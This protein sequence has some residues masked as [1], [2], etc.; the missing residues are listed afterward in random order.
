MFFR[1]IPLFL[2]RVM[3][4]DHRHIMDGFVERSML[5][6]PYCAILLCH[7]IYVPVG[8]ALGTLASCP[9]LLARHLGQH[10]EKLTDERRPE[11][12]YLL[13][14]LGGRRKRRIIQNCQP[15]QPL[16]PELG[17]DKAH[18]EAIYRHST[19]VKLPPLPPSPCRNHIFV[20]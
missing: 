2:Y 6:T 9:S 15:K 19:T 20:S 8:Q 11:S 1:D 16:S 5:V 7:S 13:R 3:N 17:P 4:F 12:R 14:Y 10:R 18:D